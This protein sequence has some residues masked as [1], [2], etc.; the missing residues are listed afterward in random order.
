MTSLWIQVAASNPQIW[1][2]QLLG[3]LFGGRKIVSV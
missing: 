2:T 3:P 1:E